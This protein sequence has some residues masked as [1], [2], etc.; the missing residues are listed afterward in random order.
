MNPT[1]LRSLFFSL[2]GALLGCGLTLGALAAGGRLDP[3]RDA[4]VRPEGARDASGEVARLKSRLAE[5]ERERPDPRAPADRRLEAAPFPGPDS[6]APSP[7]PTL[8]PAAAPSPAPKP[9]PPP[10]PGPLSVE[11]AVARLGRES[12]PKV[13]L[14]TAVAL[15]NTIKAMQD[16]VERAAAVD[17]IFA[18]FW[19][20]TDPLKRALLLVAINAANATVP[21]VE[22]ERLSRLFI[23][24]RDPKLLGAAAAVLKSRLAGED[25]AVN[26]LMDAIDRSP[27]PA[28]RRA[29]YSAFTENQDPRVTDY[30]LDSL[31]HEGDPRGQRDLVEMVGGITTRANVERVVPKLESILDRS[32]DEEVKTKALFDLAFFHY[33]HHSANAI[34]AIERYAAKELDPAYQGR[35]N[36]LLGILRDDRV[37]LND[38]V[39]LFID[40]KKEIG[41][42]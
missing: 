33:V 4:P 16:P 28:V 6:A 12:D 7:A 9:P 37:S 34:P 42:E 27:D 17:K 18:D 1:L 23:T 31:D 14:A 21:S 41:G 15:G 39:R 2:G 29:G 8:P 10:P 25:R 24:E 26:A 3:P 35:A 19:N 20:E 22:V 40:F 5:L 38:V 11:D 30:L 36:R 32:G 13:L